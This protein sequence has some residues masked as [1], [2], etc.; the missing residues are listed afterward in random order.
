MAVVISWVKNYSSANDGEVLS[1]SDLENIQTSIENH[2]HTSGLTTFLSLTDTPSTYVGQ[3]GRYVRVNAGETALEFVVGGGGSSLSY[4]T[5]FTNASLTAG[6]LTVTHALGTKF[7]VVAV[8]DNNDKAVIPDEITVTNTTTCTVD[9]SSFVTAGGGA[10]S[11]TWNI[12]VV[13]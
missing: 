13:G 10:I 5:S 7:V 3:A 11:G 4:T 9:L 12:K 1:G 8:F 2:D 6:V